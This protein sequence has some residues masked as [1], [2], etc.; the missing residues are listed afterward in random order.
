[1][2]DSC[3]QFSQQIEIMD[4]RQLQELHGHL[5]F[6]GV[7]AGILEI[8]DGSLQFD[9]E[10]MACILRCNHCGQL[11]ELATSKCGGAFGPNDNPSEVYRH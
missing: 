1:M 3:R 5:Y 2:C 4:S 9:N 8:T 11:F 10:G 7:K 6:D